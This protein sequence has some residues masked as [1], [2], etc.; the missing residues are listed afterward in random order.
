MLE[1]IE[2]CLPHGGAAGLGFVRAAAPVDPARWY[3]DAH[4]HQDPV[5]PGSLG[6]E[7]LLQ[8]LRYLAAERWG[9]A[10]RALVPAPGAGHAWWYRGQVLPSNRRY[11]VEAEVTAVDETSRTIRADGLLEVDGLV[12]YRMSGFALTM[13]GQAA[14]RAFPGRGLAR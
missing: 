9:E 8:C 10:A 14:P 11:A 3:F 2:A 13:P 1:E 6:L 4:F 12:I 7:A 5:C